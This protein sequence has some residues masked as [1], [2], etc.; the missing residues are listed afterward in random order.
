MTIN[1]E[2]ILEIYNNEQTITNTAKK[3]CEIHNIQYS[4]SIRRSFSNI[5]NKY[6][7]SVEN[8]TS[9]NEY[10]SK[11]KSEDGNRSV[12]TALDSEGKLMTIE[13]YCEYYGLDRE[14]VRSYKLVSHTG[15]PYFNIVFNDTQT[16]LHLKEFGE[17]LLE[18]ISNIKFEKIEYNRTESKNGNLL[19]VDPCDIH[20][21]KLCDSFEVGEEY[22]NQIAVKRVKEGVESLI[23][24][25]K[26]F[27]IEKILFVGGNDILHIDNPKRTTTSGTPQDTD[28]QWYSNF[29][30]AKS[31]YIDILNRLLEVADI[32]F[33]YNPSNHDYF[34]S[35]FLCDVIKTYFKDN[36]N[37]TF[38]TD[39]SHRKYFKY[40]NNLIGTTHG[41][42]AKQADLPLLMAH[43]SSDWSSC[44]NR[45]IYGHHLHH[46]VSKDYIGVTFEALRSPSG[47]DSWHHRNG[48]TGVPK[49][50]EG[51]IHDPE[52]G[53][54]ARLTHIF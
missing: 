43:E 49:A 36:K 1:I 7:N 18:E 5:I 15:V 13:K 54:V 52:H 29:L 30:I 45:Y 22:N 26:G 14:S 35:F 12:F 32:H 40:G 53:Q 21:G 16:D 44:K 50:I 47:T 10:K 33:V 8:S 19:V 31:L 20:V 39:I 2:Q 17:K 51:F 24:K 37:I 6:S 9:S 34:S 11:L 4:D 25:S 48:Y 41:D 23:E 28:G 38:D 46:K 27:N 42:G 3:Y